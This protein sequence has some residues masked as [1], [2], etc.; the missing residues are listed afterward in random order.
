MA[1]IAKRDENRVTSLLGVSSIDFL[2]PTTIAVDP[3]THALLASA[4]FTPSGTQ[5]INLTKVGGSSIS[6]GQQTT[7]A[8]LPVV[9]PASQITTLTPP[10]TVTVIQGTGTNLHTVVDSGTVNANISGSISNTNFGADLRVSSAPVTTSNPVPIQPPASGFLNVA[11]DQ[12]GSHSTVVAT[13]TTG[14]NLHTVV[15]S[16]SIT[17]NA[18]TN[19]N[20]SALALESGGNLAT[21]AGTVAAS[22]VNVNVSNATLAVTQ[23]TSPWVVSGT[24]TANPTTPTALFTGQTLVAVTNTAVA[25]SGSQAVSGIIVQ[26]LSGN[27]GNVVVGPSGIT[28]STGFELQPGQATSVA[29]DNLNKLFVNGTAGDGITYIAS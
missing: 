20:T 3:V 27:A 26:A 14:T 12:S 23:S 22:K 7:A 24:V 1:D 5:D 6:I 29:I 18:G 19:L 4:T 15:D 10:T 28:T 11:I 13:Q 2:S 8:S 17:A 9:L 21:L 16:G 25:I